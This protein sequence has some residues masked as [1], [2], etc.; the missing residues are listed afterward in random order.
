MAYVYPTI[1]FTT[2]DRVFIHLGEQRYRNNAMQISIR[3]HG[4][5][6]EPN[7]NNVEATN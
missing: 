4:G 7:L 6:K 3:D 5:F 1:R 2:L